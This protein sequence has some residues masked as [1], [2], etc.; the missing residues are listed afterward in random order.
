MNGVRPPGTCERKSGLGGTCTGPGSC[1]PSLR[2]STLLT[3]GT[4]LRKAALR[5]GCINY[6]DC[7]DAP[8]LRR[9]HPALRGPARCRR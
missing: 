2:C 7:E 8:L 1:L 6:D 9:H 3:T 4:C 5:E